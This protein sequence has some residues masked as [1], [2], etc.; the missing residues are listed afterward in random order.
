M[1]ESPFYCLS[2]SELNS[3]LCAEK[4]NTTTEHSILSEYLSDI[5]TR[6]TRRIEFFLRH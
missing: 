3:Y 5:A 2:D 1:K 6:L 4:L